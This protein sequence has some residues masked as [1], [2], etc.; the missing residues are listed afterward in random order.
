MLEAIKQADICVNLRYPNSEVCSL[1]LLE[2]MYS[3]KP[4]LTINS[5]FYAEIPENC[6]LRVNIE[7]ENNEIKEVLY[8]LVFADKKNT[9]Q[10][11]ETG[12]NAEI[13]VKENCNRKKYS[14][15]FIEFIKTADKQYEIC[16]IQ[17][18]FLKSIKTKMDNIFYDPQEMP[19]MISN[20]VNNTEYFLGTRKISG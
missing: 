3:G 8:N 4:T 13:W 10:M 7:N 6:T 11:P 19:F 16:K 17:Q 20:I 15:K 14:D 5:G 1:S 9:E 12:N 2:Q 18:E